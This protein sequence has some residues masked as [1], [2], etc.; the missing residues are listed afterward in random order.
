MFLPELLEDPKAQ[1]EI[2][3]DVAVQVVLDRLLA[4]VVVEVFDVLE[5][6]EVSAV[7]A[8]LDDRLIVMLNISLDVVD[9][10]MGNG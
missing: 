8:D 10:L 5:R 7:C 4:V 2:L 6:G 9:D 3:C 1:S